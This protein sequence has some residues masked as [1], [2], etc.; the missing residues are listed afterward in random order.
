MAGHPTLGDVPSPEAAAERGAAPA[1]PLAPIPTSPASIDRSGPVAA[2]VETEVRLL[3]RMF[4]S[5]HHRD[6]RIFYAGQLISITGTWMQQIAQGWLVLTLTGS[7]FLLGVAAAARTLPILL[8]SV[9]AGIVADRMDRRKIVI[10]ADLVMMALSIALA[11]LTL[12]GAVTIAWVLVLG[13]GLGAANAFEMP[14]RQSLVVQLTGPRH[15]ANAIA[16]NSL[17]FNSAR[18]I[19]PALAG[20]IVAA[21]GPGVAF[22]VNSFTFVPIIAGLLVITPRPVERSTSRALGALAEAVAYLRTEPRVAMLLG[23]LAA[24][25]IFASGFLF[26]GPSLARDLGQGAEGLGLVLSAAGVGAV[27][28]GLRMAAQGRRRR[29][30]RILLVA[31]LGLAASLIGVGVAGSFPATLVLMLAVGWGTVTYST[32]SNT[33]I[34][35]IVP[36]VLRGRIMSLYTV[37]MVGLMPIGSLILG[38]FADRIGTAVALGIGGAIWGVIVGLAFAG[39]ARLRGL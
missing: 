14:S 18:V 27:I 35:N 22:A 9:P 17:L 1:D 30:A 15:L 19:G 24:N 10:A 11:A 21:A 28:G 2:P 12:T 34:Q 13:A 38:A 5:M 32:T 33:V 7:P 3:G 16:L 20:L 6:F 25:T 37:V 36:E 4:E 8:L 29:R 23:L 31:G 39:S 26:L